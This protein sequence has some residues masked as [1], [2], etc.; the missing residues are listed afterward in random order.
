MD[1][2]VVVGGKKLSGTIGTSGS[3]NAALPILFS[4]LL[5]DGVHRFDNVPALRDIDSTEL[6]LAALNCD[7]ERNDHSMRVIVKPPVKAEASYDL[8]R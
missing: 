5:A 8:V 3:K 2:I 6:L 1:S 7:V 4:T